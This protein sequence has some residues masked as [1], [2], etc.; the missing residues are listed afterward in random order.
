MLIF[1]FFLTVCKLQM[2]MKIEYNE[3]LPSMP[4]SRGR[5]C[6]SPCTHAKTM[7]MEIII[8]INLLIWRVIFKCGN[9]YERF[10]L[11]CMPEDLSISHALVLNMF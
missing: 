5:S 6:G 11:K 4:W 7:T 1:M 3:R 10:L 9:T 8:K 2:K